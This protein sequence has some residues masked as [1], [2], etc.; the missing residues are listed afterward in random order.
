MSKYLGIDTSNYTTSVCLFD[1]ETNEVLQKRRLLPVSKGELGLRQSD[2]V[3]HHT[4]QLPI[5]FEELFKEASCA[6]SD[7]KAVGASFTPRKAQGSY[8]PCFTVGSG[9]ARIL[10]ASLNIPLFDFSHQQGHIASALFST[11]QMHLF[12]KTFLAFHVSGGTTDALLVNK[13]KATLGELLSVE[14]VG[15]TLDLNAGQ[16]VDRVGLMLGCDFPCGRQLETLALLHNEPIKAKPTI[17]GSDCCLSGVENICKKAY[18]TKN[19]KAYTAALCLKY[20]EESL[21]EMTKNIIEKYGDMPIVFAGGVMS[22][23]IIRNNLTQRLSCTFCEP[24][25][26]TDNACGIAVLTSILDK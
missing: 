24:Q 14:L 2:A 4:Q 16:L 3:F 10:S 7:I 21:Y 15:T 6:L 26:S 22:N 11:D 1:D 9:V 8:M 25:Y 18:D 13:E 17:K 20:I 23:S 5:L 19:D 12:D